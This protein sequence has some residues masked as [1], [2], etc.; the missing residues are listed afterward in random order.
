M[1]QNIQ[2]LS[3]KVMEMEILLKEEKTD[4]PTYGKWTRSGRS[5]LT[6]SFCRQKHKGRGVVIYTVEESDIEKLNRLS[7]GSTTQSFR[8]HIILH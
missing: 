3:N 2:H 7:V 5:T 1:H 8:Y 4:I 6:S